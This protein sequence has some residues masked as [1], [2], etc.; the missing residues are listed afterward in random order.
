LVLE[1]WNEEEPPSR[2]KCS[3]HQH[4]ASE[5]LLRGMNFSLTGVTGVR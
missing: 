3:I 2:W 4:V 5:A 1:V